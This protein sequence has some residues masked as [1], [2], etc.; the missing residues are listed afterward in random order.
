VKLILAIIFVVVFFKIAVPLYGEY[1]DNKK[2]QQ[3]NEI[4]KKTSEK[5]YKT[6]TTDALIFDYYPTS[7]VVEGE[8]Y[9]LRLAEK[10]LES[11]KFEFIQII[12]DLPAKYQ[13]RLV[14]S[15]IR[16][17]PCPGRYIIDAENE[18][19]VITGGACPGNT[20][21]SRFLIKAESISR[22]ADYAVHYKYGNPDEFDIR[23]FRFYI[24]NSKTKEIIAEQNSYQQLLGHMQ[25]DK[26]RV[27]L[28]WGSAEGAKEC[29]LT[30]P[31][32][33]IFK[34]FSK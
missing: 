29:K 19:E 30:Y 14:P 20:A 25:S 17:S 9:P 18:N 11:K 8:Y 33:F 10:L 1:V 23:S 24:E 26:N 6:A 22:R 16:N 15:I 3:F 5:I 28:G 27:R 32:D 31:I 34:I 4:C 2:F 13:D 12:Y 7:G 21:G